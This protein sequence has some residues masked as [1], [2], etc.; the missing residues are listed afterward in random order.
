MGAGSG[1]DQ[2]TRAS[3][4]HYKSRITGI[5]N[6]V[7]DERWLPVPGYAGFYEVSD[8]GNVASLA[9]STTRGRLLKVQLSPQG[10]H[11]VNLSK[12][13]RVRSFTVA[14]LVLLTFK[15]PRPPH[16]RARHG[17]SGKLDDSLE[18]LYW[19]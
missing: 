10:Y 11:M 18:N 12:Y 9:R 7:I 15:S 13:G 4:K 6:K 1:R 8:L 17:P 19:G 14:S 16:A 2:G 3:A 5:V